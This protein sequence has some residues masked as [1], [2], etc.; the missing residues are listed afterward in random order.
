MSIDTESS[1]SIERAGDVDPSSGWWAWPLIILSVFSIGW[2][3]NL[4]PA[5]SVSSSESSSEAPVDSS[6]LALLKIQSQV[7]VATAGLDPG[8]AE[9]A[10]KELKIQ[11]SGTRAIVAIALLEQFVSLAGPDAKVELESLELESSDELVILAR[12]AVAVG[13][14]EDERIRLRETMGW[15]SDLA[16]SAG[17]IESPLADQ[18]RTKAGTVMTV[19]F[20]VFALSLMG[21]VAGGILLLTLHRNQRLTGQAYRF[22]KNDSPRGVM[23]E[24]FALYLGIMAGCEMAAIWIHPGMGIVG[25]VMAVVVPL[26]W[27]RLRGVGWIPFSAALGW[28]R[29]QGWLKEIGAGLVG[30][31]G[32]MSIASIGISLTWLLSIIVG[33]VAGAGEGVADTEAAFDGTMGPEAH[34][35]VGWIYTG[36]LRAR[37][38]CLVL[39]AGFA[40]LTEETFFRGGLHRYLRGRLSFIPSAIFT[41]VIFA[42]LHPQGW[43]A[44]PALASIGFGFSL[45]REWRDSLIAPMVAHALNNTALVLVLCLV[46]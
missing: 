36:D 39:A 44:I 29:G 25:Y 30:Y 37:V 33:I 4:I 32:V 21:M 40:P 38:L 26:V 42:A 12:K 18:I 22:R 1:E 24:C 27:P 19:L 17:M 28:H 11:A 7:I 13:I 45:L 5:D 16:P 9:S 3:V 8:S 41:G 15:F 23:L 43:L 14:T 20:L 6:D 31:L 35:M 2:S 34:P 10:F 46:L